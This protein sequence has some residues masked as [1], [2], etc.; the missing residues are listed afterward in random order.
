MPDNSTDGQVSLYEAIAIAI[1]AHKA[2]ELDEAERIYR[3]ILEADAGYP[4]A[5]H[6]LGVLMHQKGESSKALDLVKKSLEF[7]P[8][9]L[10][11]WNNLGNIHKELNQLNEAAACYG[12]V[13]ENHS[14]NADALNNL[15]IVLKSMGEYEGAIEL[16][17][18]ALS[19]MPENPDV[20]QNLSNC[21][22]RMKKYG[23]A[24]DCFWQA[25]RL[26]PYNPN[27][28]CYLR[29]LLYATGQNSKLIQKLIEEWLQRD[30]DDETALHLQATFNPE[31]APD[32]A[33][34]QYVRT[35][36]D[37][38]AR[39]FDD[40]LKKLDYRAPELVGELI[41]SR[42]S[43]SRSKPLALDAG[44]GTGLCGSLI[45][46]NVSRLDG[47]DI[48]SGML[49]KAAELKCYDALYEVELTQ[50][51]SSKNADYDL[52]MSADTL[53]Y[54]GDLNKVLAAAYHALKPGGC[55]V[56][57]IEEAENTDTFKLELHGR[58]CHTI[59]YVKK[60][61]Q[62]AGLLER[63]CCSVVLRKE[64]GDEVKG[65]LVEALRID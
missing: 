9:N 43:R 52:I 51:L 49:E 44:C 4:D 12:R 28:Y 57:T 11:A 29:S 55:L 41:N 35:T 24:I 37:H 19:R 25:T 50:F 60:V 48:S 34:D 5:L 17:H 21:Y 53:V 27:D 14:E 45:R 38:F 13:L 30:P 54:F 65:Y 31:T 56:F 6:Y 15:G 40:V 47:V 10:G 7:D 64:L 63:S 26:R 22:R 59:A 58:Y 20:Y 61:L 36:F 8:E 33:N 23:S 3:L 18:Q 32:R 62:A 46:A 2:G 39:N 16:F 1:E 42:F